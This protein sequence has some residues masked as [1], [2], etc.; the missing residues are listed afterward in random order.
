V[1]LEAYQKHVEQ[2]EGLQLAIGDSA[3]AIAKRFKEISEDVALAGDLSGGLGD[4][5]RGMC[6]AWLVLRERPEPAIRSIVTQSEPSLLK[7]LDYSREVA[8]AIGD[9]AIAE[10]VLATIPLL[11]SDAKAASL[12]AKPWLEFVV[13]SLLNPNKALPRYESLQLS[14]V[15]ILLRSQPGSSIELA[16][17]QVWSIEAP[18]MSKA[19]NGEPPEEAL[20][21]IAAEILKGYLAASLGEQC[22]ALEVSELVGADKTH[23]VES[24]VASLTTAIVGFGELSMAGQALLVS[25]L[26]RAVPLLSRSGFGQVTVFRTT[27]TDRIKKLVESEEARTS[28]KMLIVSKTKFHALEVLAYVL[29]AFLGL[30]IAWYNPGYA[31]LVLFLSGL[32]GTLTRWVL[33]WK[34]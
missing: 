29:I 9:L 28:D 17:R 22:L 14:A 10:E 26:A 8:T 3:N 24:F 25:P 31:W 27:D 6:A 5:L 33:S 30:V 1:A 16:L 20:P 15:S 7:L 18:K 12:H 21:R 2:S 11:E 13:R 19:T 23:Q 32:A 34:D 4:R